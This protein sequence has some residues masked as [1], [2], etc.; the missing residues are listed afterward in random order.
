MTVKVGDKVRVTADVYFEDCPMGAICTVSKILTDDAILATLDGGD[1]FEW[2][3]RTDWYEVITDDEPD[4]KYD[5][6]EQAAKHGI[7]ITVVLKEGD[8][9]VFDGRK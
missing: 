3:L 1:G 4:T 2:C 7:K 8:A 6:A 5:Y 9:V